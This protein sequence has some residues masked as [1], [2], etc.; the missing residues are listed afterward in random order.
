VYTDDPQAVEYLIGRPAQ[1]L[2]SKFNP[3]TRKEV[4]RFAVE[5]ERLRR[6]I[7][8]HGAIVARFAQRPT[9]R[10]PNVN[11]LEDAESL[12]VIAR[13]DTVTIRGPAP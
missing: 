13:D 7:H 2:P 6:E 10:Y 5:L 4:P 12:V 3:L 8:L 9:S 1:R 11:E